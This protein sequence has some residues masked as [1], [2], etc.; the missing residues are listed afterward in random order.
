MRLLDFLEIKQ[1][2]LLHGLFHGKAILLV[3]NR[4]IVSFEFADQLDERIWKFESCE[5]ASLGK[6]ERHDV[7]GGSLRYYS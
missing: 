7:S 6:V 2:N 5:H 1:L 3:H 4:R